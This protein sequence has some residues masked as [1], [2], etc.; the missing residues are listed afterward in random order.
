MSLSLRPVLAAVAC[1]NLLAVP[2]GS[3]DVS[4]NADGSMISLESDLPK[5]YGGLMITRD[6]QRVRWN[7]PEGSKKE[8]LEAWRERVLRRAVEP[9]I[10]EDTPA[11][12][13]TSLQKGGKGAWSSPEA[14]RDKVIELLA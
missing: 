9:L 10:L 8:G 5:M 3:M 14:I 6:V 1:L 7:G 4:V 12:E 13:W 2:G 11:K